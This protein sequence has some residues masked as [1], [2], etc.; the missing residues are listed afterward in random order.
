MVASALAPQTRK[1]RFLVAVR[2]GLQQPA[3]AA[4][5]AA[6]LDRISDG[7]LLINVVTGGDPIELRGEGVALAHDERY[8]VTDE[9]LT[10]WRALMAG[11]TVSYSGRHLMIEQGRLH[12]PP[13]QSPH[14]PLYFGGSS[15]AGQRVAAEQVDIYLTWGDRRRS[16]REGRADARA[17]R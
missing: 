15:T 8:Q 9:F 1:L 12:F 5:M 16:W 14:P 2:P 4:R 13:V 10:I 17:S 11:E 7:R 3:Q 6:T